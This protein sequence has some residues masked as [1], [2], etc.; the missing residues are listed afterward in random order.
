MKRLVILATIVMLC[1]GALAQKTPSKAK[2]IVKARVWTNEAK[3]SRATYVVDVT[4]T[5]IVVADEQARFRQD[6]M[7][8]GAIPYQQLRE[9]SVNRKGSF[10]RGALTGA[11]VVGVTGAALGGAL[12]SNT[13]SDCANPGGLTWLGAL[14]GGLTGGFFGGL[15]GGIIGGGSE[16]RFVIGGNKKKFDKMRLTVLEMA[17]GQGRVPK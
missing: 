8:A 10:G 12:A 16:R 17:Y 4:D 7:N 11:L 1:Q 6:F 14:T 5:A 2:Y 9:V 15:I 13:C 3:Y